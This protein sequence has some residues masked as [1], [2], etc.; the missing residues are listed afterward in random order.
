MHWKETLRAEQVQRNPKMPGV[1]EYGRPGGED[2]RIN[3]AKTWKILT[4][5]KRSQINSVDCREAL[6]GLGQK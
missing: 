1:C 3:G 4:I 6:K 2:G 5:T